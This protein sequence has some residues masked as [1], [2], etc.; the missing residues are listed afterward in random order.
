MGS[1]QSYKWWENTYSEFLNVG[2]HLTFCTQEILQLVTS[3]SDRHW[4]DTV[5][6]PCAVHS[7]AT[8]SDSTDE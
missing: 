6:R 5:Y 8:G 3:L 4:L 2:N 7:I 1:L